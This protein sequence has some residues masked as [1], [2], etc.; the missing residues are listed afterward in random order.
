MTT[1]LAQ[2]KDVDVD[3][4]VIDFVQNQR[5]ALVDEMH[6]AGLPN[7][8]EDRNV[9]LKALSDMSSTAIGRKRIKV[10]Q[11]VGMSQAGAAALI[12]EILV[13]TRGQRIYEAEAEVVSIVPPEL[14]EDVVPTPEL[15]PGE[16]DWNPPALEF[17]KF[18]AD[19]APPEEQ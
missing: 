4:A 12:G 11:E 2:E 9:Y 19:T 17:D 10:D 14:S 1:A 3:D 15:V 18:M 7:N 16:L 13:G 5:R 8:T 6:K